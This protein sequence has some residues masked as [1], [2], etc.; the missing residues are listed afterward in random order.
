MKTIALFNDY[1]DGIYA[2]KGDP[3]KFFA[4]PM[5]SELSPNLLRL[6]QEILFSLFEEIPNLKSFKIFCDGG[7]SMIIS[8]NNI[9][10]RSFS[11]LM[12]PDVLR[13]WLVEANI[14]ESE[15][16]ILN[17]IFLAIP[18]DRTLFSRQDYLKETHEN[19]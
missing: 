5:Q 1:Y 2:G 19:P 14:K 6:Q 8:V 16:A 18:R 17:K 7:T 3:V 10:L 4:L 15:L 13:S 11:S 9:S 12:K